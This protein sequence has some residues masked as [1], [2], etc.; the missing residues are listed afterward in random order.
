MVSYKC[1]GINT[2]NVFVFCLNTRLIKFWHESFQLWESPVKGFLLPSND[3]LIISNQGINVIAIG[4]KEARVIEDAEKFKRKIHS[5]GSCNYLKV[6]PE[7]HILFACQYYDNRQICIQDQYQ[8]PF[9]SKNEEST[10]F[11]DQTKFEDV[12]K[13]KLH[14]I[15]LRELLLVQSL[16]SCTTP[17]EISHL[18]SLQP[19]PHV[20]FK[21]YLELGIKSM[22]PYLAFDARSLAHLLRPENADFFL[23]NSFDEFPVFYKNPD[24]GSAIDV[25]SENNQIR[26]VNEMIKY[27]IHYQNSYKYAHLFQSNLIQLIRD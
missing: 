18:V 6:E 24:G 25:A 3:F 10:D 7:Q 15:T 1:I 19:S 22:V 8:T 13:I 17:S 2:Y 23:N 16:Y 20:F 26:S 11:G 5:L 14:D 27:I 9:V 21:V 12:Y 4:N